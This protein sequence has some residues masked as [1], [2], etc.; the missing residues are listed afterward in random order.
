MERRMS[1]LERLRSDLLKL[2]RTAVRLMVCVVVVTEVVAD[3]LLAVDYR[4]LWRESD[5]YVQ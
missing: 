4:E 3:V 1:M 5:D 2:L